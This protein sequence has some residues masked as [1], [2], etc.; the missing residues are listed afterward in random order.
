MLFLFYQNIFYKNID[1]ETCEFLEY[2]KNKPEAKI[3]NTI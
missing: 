3:F 2:Y 1:T